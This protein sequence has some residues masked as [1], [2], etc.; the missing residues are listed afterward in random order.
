MAREARKVTADWQ[1]PRS[2][3]GKLIPMLQKQMADLMSGDRNYF[4]MYETTT[5]GTPISPVFAQAE[6]LARWLADHEVTVFGSWPATREQWLIIIENPETSIPAFS[7]AVR[8]SRRI[9]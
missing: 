3:D 8:T 7:K 4:Q 6:E 2:A 9:H 5:E 1:H